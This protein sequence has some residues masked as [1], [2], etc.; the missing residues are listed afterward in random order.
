MKLAFKD[1]TS[2]SVYRKGSDDFYT[3]FTS[4]ISKFGFRLDQCMGLNLDEGVVSPGGQRFH[5]VRQ[6][7]L[8]L[9]RSKYE[10]AKA[11]MMY[12]LSRHKS[13]NLSQNRVRSQSGTILGRLFNRAQ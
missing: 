12:K 9:D 11:K 6:S 4:E 10:N 5:P 1:F 8:A 7:Q 13:H 2:E 3:Q